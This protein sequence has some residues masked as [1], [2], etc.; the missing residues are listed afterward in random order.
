[1]ARNLHLNTTA[2]QLLLSLFFQDDGQYPE[3]DSDD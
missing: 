3:S 1:M 2:G